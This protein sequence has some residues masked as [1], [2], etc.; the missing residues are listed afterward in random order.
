MQID[1]P[2]SERASL[3][4]EYGSSSLSVSPPRKLKQLSSSTS[5]LS[6]YLD[7]TYEKQLRRS[8]VVKDPP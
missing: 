8:S 1:I 6:V 3:E 5:I 4:I 7:L 2:E